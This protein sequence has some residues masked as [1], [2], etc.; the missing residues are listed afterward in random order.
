MH[1]IPR[2]NR[3]GQKRDGECPTYTKDVKYL[4]AKKELCRTKEEQNKSS[5]KYDIRRITP[6]SVV[7]LVP[8]CTP[9][10]TLSL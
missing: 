1:T 3:V 4:G 9:H 10:L 7:V 6:Y 2:K 8:T 5:L